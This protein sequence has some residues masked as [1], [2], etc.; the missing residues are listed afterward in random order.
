[1]FLPVIVGQAL[2]RLDPTSDPWNPETLILLTL[3]MLQEENS[4]QNGKYSLKRNRSIHLDFVRKVQ[5]SFLYCDSKLV[6]VQ[7]NFVF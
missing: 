3:K 5:V 4:Y 2:A 6:L 1:M 7:N